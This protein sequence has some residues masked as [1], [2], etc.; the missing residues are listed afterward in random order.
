MKQRAMAMVRYATKKLVYGIEGF[1]ISAW[2]KHEHKCTHTH[3]HTYI[4]IH[5]IYK[6]TVLYQP[7]QDYQ[8]DAAFLNSQRMIPSAL[9][10]DSL[11]RIHSNLGAFFFD[12]WWMIHPF[13][14]SWAQGPSLP[15]G[16]TLV[17]SKPALSGPVFEAQWCDFMFHIV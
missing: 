15:S 3:P 14:A 7:S 2:L 5:I 4:Y 11:Q 1:P 12:S 9:C 16:T 17:G 10:Q 13:P 6:C 8:I